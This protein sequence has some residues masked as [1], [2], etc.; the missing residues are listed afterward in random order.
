MVMTA[1]ASIMA[2]FCPMHDLGPLEKE[3]SALGCF[4]ALDTPFSNLAGLNSSASSPHT[5]LS[6][7]IVA[8]GILRMVPSGTLMP[9]NLALVPVLLDM[10]ETGLYNLRVSRRNM[11]SKFILLSMSPVGTSSP[12]IVVTSFLIFLI[13]SGCVLSKNMVQVSRCEV[14]S[15]PPKK[16]VL[17]SAMISS[18]LNCWLSSCSGAH[19]SNINPSKSFP[20]PMVSLLASRILMMFLSMLLTFLSSDHIFRFFLVGR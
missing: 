17:H 18:M 11:L 2:K 1:L 13:H 8:I 20:Y 14:V 12:H 10:S 16:K 4:A 3:S 9:P 19:V 5:S 7:W 15:C 6:R